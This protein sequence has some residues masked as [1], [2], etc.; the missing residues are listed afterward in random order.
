MKLNFLK[1]AILA[2]FIATT[3]SSCWMY[4]FTG[5]SIPPD[6]KTV[7]ISYFPNRAT[8]I[9]PTLS[10]EL[11][12]TIKDKFISQTS[13]GLIESNGDLQFHGEITGYRTSPAAISGDEKAT[14]NRLTISIKVKFVN[15]IDDTKNFESSFSRYVDFNS[16]L[17]FESV[18]LDLNKDVIEQ[19]VD[20][21]FNK[22]VVNW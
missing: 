15:L 11:T 19:L 22:A 9:Q 4:T 7:S 2:I 5:A 12:E 6:A 17:S 21:I 14:Q 18:E 10:Q 3:F 8:L 20:D 13:L 1:I 16:S